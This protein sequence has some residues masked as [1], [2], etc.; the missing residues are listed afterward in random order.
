MSGSMSGESLLFEA[1]PPRGVSATSAV[2]VGPCA[3]CFWLGAIEAGY[4][5]LPAHCQTCGIPSVLR[6]RGWQILG[7]LWGPWFGAPARAKPWRARMHLRVLNLILRTQFWIGSPTTVSPKFR[8][9]FMLQSDSD[10]AATF[11][12]WDDAMQAG[13]SAV[14]WMEA[15]A[16]ADDSQLLR[17]VDEAQAA[18]Q[19]SRQEERPPIARYMKPTEF[20]YKARQKQ[21]TKAPVAED[22]LA[23]SLAETFALVHAY[24]PRNCTSQQLTDWGRS[25]R[26]TFQEGSQVDNINIQ[27][28]LS[29]ISEKLELVKLGYGTDHILDSGR[30]GLSL[31]RAVNCLRKGLVGTSLVCEA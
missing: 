7:C 30:F 10:F 5:F 27:Q 25:R 13:G 31:L 8:R 3:L 21:A 1:V 26:T 18:A 11:T 16:V 19:S 24:R 28:A 4:E 17:A 9:S 14:A 29:P 6:C 2:Q 12:S 15:T 23:R 22:D 20:F